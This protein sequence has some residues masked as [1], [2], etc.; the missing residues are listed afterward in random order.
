VSPHRDSRG[1][2]EFRPQA[3][4]DC[5]RRDTSELAYGP[6]VADPEQDL[7]PLVADPAVFRHV[8][9]HLTSGVS[10]ITTVHAGT[11]AGMTAS[12][13]T[14]LSMDPPMM[15]VCINRA[16]PM[17]ASVSGSQCFAINVL[18]EQGAE[19]ARQFA[20]PSDD[21]FRDVRISE[22]LRG[23][24]LLDEALA[25]LECEVV[26]EVM[27]GTHKIFLGRVVRA[28]AATDGEPLAYFRGNFGRFQFAVNDDVYRRVRSLVVERRYAANSTVDVVELAEALSVDEA[29]AFYALTRLSEDGLLRRDPERGYVVVPLDARSSDYA[30]D[31]RSMIQA[32]VVEMVLPELA[33]N[34]IEELA[35]YVHEMAA[36][37]T[38]D[39]F[40][41]FD[42]YLD[43]NYR[44][45]LGLVRLGGNPA[46]ENAF[47]SLGLRSV[48]K[49]SF[50]ATSRTSTEFVA[51]HED[52]LAGLWA[53]DVSATVGA[54]LRYSK[55]AKERVREVLREHGGVL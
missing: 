29:S 3:I 34:R 16:A 10:V 35:D 38:D 20:K 30:F 54:L 50:G 7:V 19:L 9:G 40:V 43:A 36:Q 28:R 42:A 49:R 48:M 47:D 11:R 12:S 37:I 46:L 41:D 14:S 15:L 2:R 6:G 18:S 32:S 5:V 22:G 31:A 27:G 1:Q 4:T 39:E 33:E 44:F 25:H 52:I 51:V 53:R 8:V 13:V 21:K 26:E 45:H 55:M 17:A 24:P 23:M